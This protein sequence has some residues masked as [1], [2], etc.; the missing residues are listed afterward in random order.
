MGYAVHATPNSL[1]GS[2]MGRQLY[3]SAPKFIAEVLA[4]LSADADTAHTSVVANVAADETE[5]VSAEKVL[6]VL[7]LQGHITQVGEG[8]NATYRLADSGVNLLNALGGV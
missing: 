5:T 8:E 7:A 2:R 4:N 3:R 6:K 1:G